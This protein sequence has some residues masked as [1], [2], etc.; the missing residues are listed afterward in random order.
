MQM[1]SGYT[2]NYG[3]CQWQRSDQF[4][5][6]EFNQDN[7]R[8]DAVLDQVE[9]LAEGASHNVYNLLLRDYYEGLDTS[10]KKAMVF[11]GFRDQTLIASLSKGVVLG[12]NR[13]ALSKNGQENVE[14]GYDGNASLKN[15]PATRTI[16]ATGTGQLTGFRIKTSLIGTEAVTCSV[17]YTIYLNGS[18]AHTGIK[19]LTIPVEDTEHTLLLPAVQLA[20]GDTFS[21]KLYAN[22]NGCFVYTSPEGGVGGTILITPVAAE[23]GSLTTPALTLPDRTLLRGW[24]RYDGGDVMLSVLEKGGTAIPFSI[25]ERRETVNL[26]REPCTE[27]AFCLEEGFSASGDLTFRLDLTLGDD[28]AMSVFDYGII[29]G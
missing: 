28:D 25:L 9:G 4:L 11:D 26:Q 10:W 14:L 23:T 27:A 15:G 2:A 20:A 5:R 1:A 7:Q 21:I 12:E 18:Q 22:S 8:I 29:L 13:L 24:L 16:T 17:T 3:L 19:N 6:E